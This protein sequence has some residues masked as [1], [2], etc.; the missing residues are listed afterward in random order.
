M[1]PDQAS[2]AEIQPSY[3]LN[4]PAGTV[5]VRFVDQSL[6]TRRAEIVAFQAPSDSEIAYP[7]NHETTY[8]LRFGVCQALSNSEIAMASN[9]KTTYMLRFGV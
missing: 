3:R 2:G 4:S 7:S 5:V 8:V 9:P 6:K 1:R